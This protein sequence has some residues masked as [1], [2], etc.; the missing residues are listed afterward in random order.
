MAKLSKETKI[1]RR[2]G[3]YELRLS[4]LK[5]EVEEVANRTVK[6]VYG[7]LSYEYGLIFYLL[8]DNIP[9]EEGLKKKTSEEIKDDLEKVEFLVYMMIYTN[10][11]FSN[12]EF[13]Q[14]YWE[15]VSEFVNKEVPISDED[16]KKIVEEM[17]AEHEAKNKLE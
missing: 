9:T 6:H 14:K 2:F 12:E 8:S 7:R 4:D 17:K 16:D 5:V 13:R 3:N 1:K 15:L 11:I 10:L